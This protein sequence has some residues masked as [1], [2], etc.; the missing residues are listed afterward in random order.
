VAYTHRA[1]VRWRPPS[2]AVRY[3]VYHVTAEQ[4]NGGRGELSPAWRV[5]LI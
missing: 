4:P 2:G 5:W 1:R 3:T